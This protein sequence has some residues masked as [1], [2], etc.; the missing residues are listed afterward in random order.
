VP[1]AATQTWPR[2]VP[3]LG[4]LEHPRPSTFAMRGRVGPRICPIR[5]I[6]TRG[7][8]MGRR[9]GHAFRSGYKLQ[10]KN[11]KWPTSSESHLQIFEYLFIFSAPTCYHLI[12]RGHTFP[13]STTL[14]RPALKHLQSPSP[15]Y[16]SKH[17]ESS[18]WG[19]PP[20]V[21]VF[22]ERRGP[23]VAPN[24]PSKY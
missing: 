2:F 1:S 14:Y 23:A 17:V 12:A 20:L 3:S 10:L 22:G 24:A 16:P 21:D 19:P 8:E 13:Q 6:R 15:K 9:V 4:H 11:A 18:V 7:R 5:P